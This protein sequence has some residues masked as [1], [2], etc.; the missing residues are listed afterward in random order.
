MSNHTQKDTFSHVMIHN[1]IYCTFVIST[2][3]SNS[4]LVLPV[5]VS[6]KEII[7]T[8]LEIRIPSSP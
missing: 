3:I 2:G 1:I 8:R 5:P 6:F 7:K 4:E